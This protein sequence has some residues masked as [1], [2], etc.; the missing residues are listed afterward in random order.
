[1]LRFLPLILKQV[2]RH[3][4]RTIL[5]LAGV[6]IA[7]FLFIA[8]QTL[9]QAVETSTRVAATDNTLVVYRENRFCPATSRLPESYQDR[10]ARTPGVAEVIPMKVVVNNCAA[11]LDVVTF[12]GV[13]DDRLASFK[14]HWEVLS[15]SIE[16]WS[17]RSD[18]ALVGERLADRRGYR[19]GQS[20]DAAGV[21]VTVAAVIRSTEAQDQNVA[22]VHLP[23]LQRASRTG[24]GI[25]TQFNVKLADPSQSEEVAH[26]IDAQFRSDQEPTVTRPER[27]FVA[28]AASDIVEIVGFTRYLGWGCLAAVLA[29]VANAIVLTV[30]DRVKEHAILQTLGFR[31]THIAGLIVVEGLVIALAGGAIGTLGAAAA[32][33]YGKFTLATEAVSLNVNASWTVVALG[34]FIS[35]AVGMAAGLIPAWQAGRREIAQCFRAV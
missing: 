5:T 7:M 31:S 32:L 21:K 17:K 19:A 23:F 14:S 33:Q 28:Q 24:L 13:P 34:L 9:Q 8:V 26:A 35:A 30:Q 25:V 22:Y 11:N 3:R 16:D 20:F 18:A 27:A 15:G 6:A 29:L 1:M 12:R 4:T 10:I 2:L